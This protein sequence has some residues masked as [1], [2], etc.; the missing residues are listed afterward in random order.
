MRRVVSAEEMR[1]CDETAIRA[2]GI[3]SLLLMENAGAG[4]ARCV[5]RRYGKKLSQP[6]AIFCGKGNNAGDGFVAARHLVN[7]G[8]PVVIQMLM[9]PAQLRGD[10]KTNFQILQRIQKKSAGRLVIRRF[11]ASSAADIRPS[12]V[13]DAL[14][15]TGF[16]GTVSKPFSDA[17]QSMNNYAVPV[18]SVDI[19][20]GVNGT[21]GTADSDCVHANVTVTMGA[22]KTGLLCNQGRQYSGDHEIID[23]GIPVSVYEAGKL[24]TG[25]V[26]I[27]D[28]AKVLPVRPL[29]VHKYSVG[30]VFVLGGSKGYTGAAALTASAALRTGAGAVVLGTAETVYPIL[31]RKL[32]ETIVSPLPATSQGSVSLNA[33]DQ[34]VKRMKWADITVIGPGLSR[35]E[36]TMALVREILRLARGKILLDADALNA[37]S[38]SESSFLRTA[39][40]ELVVTPH[41]GEFSGLSGR[42][43]H[44]IEAHRIE[45]ARAYANPTITAAPGGEA[46][47]NAT[48]NPGMATVG[49]GDVLSGMI[50]ALW[51]QGTTAEAAAYAG[52]YLHGLSG[53]LAAA[54]MGLQS[55]VAQDLIDFLPPAFRAVRGDS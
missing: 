39:R 25:L 28:V 45:Y 51:A 40:P 24:K 31:A 54:K 35:Q 47:V 41:A 48:G 21:T 43:S 52:V 32:S 26:E 20:S 13:V 4:I 8:V 33:L 16:S 1:W 36:E 12:L 2:F 3:P 49:S 15:G 22:L 7:A 34:I 37:L 30:K 44:E 50:G 29:N 6:V 9:F 55:V 19:P 10:A 17:I 38:G 11:S 53:D 46:Y 5:L 42:P 27:E 23:V 18:V 14:F